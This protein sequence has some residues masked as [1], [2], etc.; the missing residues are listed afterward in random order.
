MCDDY[1]IAIF[2]YTFLLKMYAAYRFKKT[3]I[4]VN[5]LANIKVNKQEKGLMTIVCHYFLQ[6]ETELKK[7][8]DVCELLDMARTLRDFLMKTGGRKDEELLSKLARLRLKPACGK[9]TLGRV[10]L[11]FTKKVH[12]AVLLQTPTWHL[13][14]HIF[15][16][17]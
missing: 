17:R 5:K 6:L 3:N 15:L 1:K 14:T 2:P 16:H 11:K 12:L 10:S 7:T 4:T 9:K 8:V 13:P